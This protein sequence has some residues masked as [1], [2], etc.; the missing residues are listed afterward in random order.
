[1]TVYRASRAALYLDFFIRFLNIEILKLI[2][3][4]IISSGSILIYNELMKFRMQRE[5]KSF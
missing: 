5:K 3:S 1:M 4:V 2:F